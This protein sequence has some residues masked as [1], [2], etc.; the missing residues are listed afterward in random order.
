MKWKPSVSSGGGQVDEEEET[1]LM[2]V[3]EETDSKGAAELDSMIVTRKEIHLKQGIDIANIFG[4]RSPR[5]PEGT[6]GITDQVA[7]V[8]TKDRRKKTSQFDLAY[9]DVGGI[10]VL[11][12]FDTCST[13]TLIHRE[14]IEE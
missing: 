2:T 12:A 10:E 6:E 7:L 5:V 1:Y 11:A 4:Y 13:A 14:L 8:V 3:T 9:I